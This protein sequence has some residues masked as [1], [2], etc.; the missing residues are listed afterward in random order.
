M[1]IVPGYKDPVSIF[2]HEPHLAPMEA[3]SKSENGQIIRTLRL[4]I[5]TD[6]DRETILTQ[7]ETLMGNQQLIWVTPY[8]PFI[9][10]ITLGYVVTLLIGD[11]I[12]GI[13]IMLL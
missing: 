7:I 8:L 2:K 11:I 10:F 9:V 5:R 12:F 6:E 13:L 1:A 3:P 4:F